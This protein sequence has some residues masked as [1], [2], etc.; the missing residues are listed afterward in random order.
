[1]KSKTTVLITI[2]ALS[3]IFSFN[4]FANYG[5]LLKGYSDI[6]GKYSDAIEKADKGDTAGAL[7]DYVGALGDI[8][9]TTEEL[10]KTT[11]LQDVQE[12]EEQIDAFIKYLDTIDDKMKEQKTS[13]TD[14]QKIT[15]ILTRILAKMKTLIE[16]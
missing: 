4:T 6:L 1:M 2:V 16:K 12:Y 13:D 8:Y 7:K 11:V 9:K 10:T 5:D 3:C 14:K 15:K